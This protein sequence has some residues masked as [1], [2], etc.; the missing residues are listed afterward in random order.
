MVCKKKT[1]E[2]A[3]S[4]IRNLNWILRQKWW[5]L[6]KAFCRPD[7]AEPGDNPLGVAAFDQK[8]LRYIS[9]DPQIKPDDIICQSMVVMTLWRLQEGHGAPTMLQNLSIWQEDKKPSK[10]NLVNLWETEIQ[11]LI[12]KNQLGRP[13]LSHHD[14]YDSFHHFYPSTPP[15]AWARRSTSFKSQVHVLAEQAAVQFALSLAD[16]H[17]QLLAASVV[18]LCLGLDHHDELNGLTDLLL[19]A[20]NRADSSDSASFTALVAHEFEHASRE[21]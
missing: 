20:A 7:A 13:T 9:T 6:S 17:L 15:S 21:F 4:T 3:A 12:Q 14:N 11:Q 18:K 2:K 10:S 1:R 5:N 19:R 16:Q 8:T